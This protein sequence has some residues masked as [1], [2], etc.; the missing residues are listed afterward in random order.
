MSKNLKHGLVL[1]LFVVALAIFLYNMGYLDSHS[2]KPGQGAVCEI[3]HPKTG[4]R[5]TTT[6][7]DIFNMARESPPR[8]YQ[9]DQPPGGWV[10]QLP[11][12]AFGWVVSPGVNK[13]PAPVVDDLSNTGPNQ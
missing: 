8:A 10:A 6:W 2:P 13:T 5:T 11:D 7:L 12:K 3:L 4:A 9:S 1:S